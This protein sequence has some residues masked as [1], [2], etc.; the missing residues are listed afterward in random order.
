MFPW[1]TPPHPGGS[2]PSGYIPSGGHGQTLLRFPLEE[3]LVAPGW[4]EQPYQ[5]LPWWG[6]QWGRHSGSSDRLASWRSLG[7]KLHMWWSAQW[8]GAAGASCWL[9]KHVDPHAVPL[10]SVLLCIPMEE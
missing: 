7:V 10:M 9:G 4:P 5:Q 8:K 6:L 1:A 2:T 3:P